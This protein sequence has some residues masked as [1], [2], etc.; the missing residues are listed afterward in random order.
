[1]THHWTAAGDFIED[2]ISQG[3]SELCTQVNKGSQVFLSLMDATS[4]F[5]LCA[6]CHSLSKFYGLGDFVVLS[7]AGNE[8]LT[9]ESRIHLVY[10]SILMAVNSI[11]W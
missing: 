7:P 10:S 4:D 3:K 11:Q 2:P 8:M 9:T 1:V 5:N 6:N